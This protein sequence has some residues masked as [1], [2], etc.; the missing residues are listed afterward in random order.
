MQELRIANDLPTEEPV[1][2]R[3]LLERAAHELVA[4]VP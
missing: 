3:S 1:T 2:L 4:K